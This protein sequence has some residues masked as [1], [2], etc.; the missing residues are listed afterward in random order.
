[1]VAVYGGDSNFTASTSTPGTVTVTTTT[2]ITGRHNGAI[3][4]ASGTSVLLVNARVNGAIIVRRGGSLD[5]EN[6]T[7]AALVADGSAALRVCASIAKGSVNVSNATG[8]V[9][10]GDSGDDGCA[11]NTI[12]GS[13]HMEN[14]AHGLEAIGNHVRGGVVDTGNSGAG[15]FPEDSGPEVSGNGR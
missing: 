14:N 12:G 10:I 4:V 15:P 3:I 5:V 2:T 11:P 8:F 6:S 13:L 9:L 7:F 1:V